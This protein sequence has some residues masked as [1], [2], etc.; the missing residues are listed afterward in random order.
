MAPADQWFAIPINENFPRF[1]RPT[2]AASS[3][4]K[5]SDAKDG[6]AMDG[7]RGGMQ[8]FRS[9]HPQIAQMVWGDGS[10]RVFG[11]NAAPA[12]LAAASTIRGGELAD[13]PPPGQ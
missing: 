1:N 11:N 3:A 12:T 4:T 2:W 7:S 6:T 10:V 9:Y 8:G 5:Y 13:P